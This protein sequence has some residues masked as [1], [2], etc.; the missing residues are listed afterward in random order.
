MQASTTSRHLDTGT[1]RAFPGT[2]ASVSEARAWVAGILAGFP[3]AADAELMASE[4]ATNAVLHSASGLP[5]GLCLNHGAGGPDLTI[6][7][8]VIVSMTPA[9]PSLCP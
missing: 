1:T 6:T 8:Q 5:G 7:R 4:L 9:K 3:A 2:P